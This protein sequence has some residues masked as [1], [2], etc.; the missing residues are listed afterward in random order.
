MH[1]TLFWGSAF[2]SSVGKAIFWESLL[3]IFSLK[4]SYDIEDSKGS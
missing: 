4:N 2:L 1:A 3:V